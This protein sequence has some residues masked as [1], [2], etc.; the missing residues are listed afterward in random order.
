MRATTSEFT[1]YVYLLENYLN[2]S[3][4]CL[5]DPIKTMAV[6]P[7]EKHWQMQQPTTHSIGCRS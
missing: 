6:I 4:P 5:T 7:M 2:E 3:V 1:S